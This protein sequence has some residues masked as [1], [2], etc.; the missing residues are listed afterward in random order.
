MNHS[1]YDNIVSAKY[2]STLDHPITM[3][4]LLPYKRNPDYCNAETVA[5][6]SGR[7]IKYYL[8]MN[9]TEACPINNHDNEIESILAAIQSKEQQR[10]S[11]IAPEPELPKPQDGITPE[12]IQ[13]LLEDPDAEAKEDQ[14]DNAD[15]TE[16]HTPFD[17]I[18]EW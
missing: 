15:T 1:I 18:E 10:I 5:M 9:Q 16:S 17:G 11:D 6:Q 12:Q 4:D 14:K 2:D 3:Y 8:C 7:V 13:T